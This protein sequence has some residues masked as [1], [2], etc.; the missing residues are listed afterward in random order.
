VS[1]GSA[2]VMDLARTV[3]TFFDSVSLVGAERVAST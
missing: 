2:V 3:G 1:L